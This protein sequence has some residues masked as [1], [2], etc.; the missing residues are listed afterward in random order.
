ML[1]PLIQNLNMKPNFRRHSQLFLPINMHAQ[2]QF[3]LP[4]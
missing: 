1:K 3:Y 2:K 4:H